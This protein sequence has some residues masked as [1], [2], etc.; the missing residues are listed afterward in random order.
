VKRYRLQQVS[1]DK[2][3]ARVNWLP[4]LSAEDKAAAARKLQDLFLKRVGPS[5]KVEVEEVPEFKHGMG[6][7]FPLVQ[8]LGRSSAE[9]ASRSYNFRF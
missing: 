5:V 8:G 3:I 7:K 9:L 4:G 2:L 1:L 6:E